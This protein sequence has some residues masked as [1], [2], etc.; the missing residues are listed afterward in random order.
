MKSIYT[1]KCRA[2]DCA[3]VF[4]EYTEYTTTL[5]CPRCGSVADK[6]ITAPQ[7]K[8]EGVTGSF[9]GAAMSWEKKRVEKLAQE[10][11]LAA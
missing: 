8:L 6:V 1:F 11:K 5:K 2:A 7:I 4:D 9:P 10:R 3:N